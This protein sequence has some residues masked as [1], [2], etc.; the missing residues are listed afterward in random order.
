MKQ[1]LDAIRADP[2]HAK[3]TRIVDAVVLKIDLV[4]W[5][6]EAMTMHAA[7]NSRRIL[8][9]DRYS[10]KILV[11]ATLQDLSA[12]SRLVEIRVRNDI[13]M[14]SLATAIGAMRRHVSTQ[15]ADELKE[16]STA[17]LRASF[18]DRVLKTSL[19]ILEEGTA[20]TGMIDLLIRDIDAAGY[21]FKAVID[22]L[23]LLEG[24]KGG[25][26]I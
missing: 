21:S 16:F 2:N 7:R 17:G 14:A 19:Q 26:V 20:L 3:F 24:N 12:R 22:C 5:T 18:V 25:R 13:Q 1:L 15:Y 23:K 10:A 9:E 6:A 8:G 4:A 11:D